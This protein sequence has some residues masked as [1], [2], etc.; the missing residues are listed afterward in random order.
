M[1]VESWLFEDKR[2]LHGVALS[3]ILAGS[4]VL[5]LL[6]TNV[7]VRSLV[8]GPGAVWA[9]PACDLG[10]FAPVKL[11][12]NVGSLEFTLFYVGAM[13]LALRTSSVGTRV[14]WDRSWSSPT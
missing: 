10:E 13:M 1:T 8:F 6:I 11:L 5:G 7:G 9:K 14:S 12:D 3:R 2:A 4:S